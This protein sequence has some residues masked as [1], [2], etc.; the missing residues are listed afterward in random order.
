[1][2][3]N[4]NDNI[5]VS[6]EGKLLD[7][8]WGPFPNTDAAYAAVDPAY[9]Q[10]GMFAIINSPS[11][12]QLWW[13][14]NN[15]DNLVLFSGNSSV[16][17][18][19]VKNQSEPPVPGETFFPP[20]GSVD[21]IY[22]DKSE[23]KSYYWTTA[24]GGKYELTS[25]TSGVEVYPARNGPFPTGFPTEGVE[26]IVYVAADTDYS[27]LWD[28][29]TSTYLQ[30]TNNQGKSAYDIWLEEGNTGTKEDFL[31][32]L[33]GPQGPEGLQGL[34]GPQGE[35]GPAG[36]T[37]P[38][39]PSG[40][41]TING[42]NYVGVWSSL[43]P[44]TFDYGDVVSYNGESYVRVVATSLDN[45]S[46]TPDSNSNWVLLAAQGATG[47]TGPQGPVGDTGPQGPQG[48]GGPQGPQGIDGPQGIAGPQG[49]QG[50]Q[51][52]DGPQGDQGP[53]GD[54]GDMGPA[55]PTGD[56]GPQGVKGDAGPVGPA[57]LTWK[58]A[59]VANTSYSK[60]DAV[61]YAGAS[62]FCLLNHSGISTI[63]SNDP[64]RW[65]LLASQGAVGPQGPT[66]AT[67]ATGPQG[68]VGPQGP[69]GEEGPRGPQGNPGETGAQGPAGVQGPQGPQGLTGPIGLQGPP[70][71]NGQNALWNFTQAYNPGAAYAVGDI[72]TYDGE[73][74]YRLDANG[75]NVGDVPQ[76][77]T[78]WTKLAAKGADGAGNQTLQQV[79]DE[80][81]TATDTNISLVGTSKI[82]FDNLAKLQK[83]TTNAGASGGIALKC[84]VD[85]ELKWEAGR[86]YIMQQ[87]GNT[88]REVRYTLTTPPTANDDTTQG[89]VV[90]S[91]WILDDGTTYVCSDP[92]PGAALWDIEEVSG[93]IDYYVDT[94]TANNYVITTGKSLT[95]NTTGDTYLI[96]FK[97]PNTGNSTLDVDGIGPVNIFNSKTQT[98]LEAGNIPD[99]SVHL[100]VYTG[101][102][103]E[104]VTVGGGT[105]TGD[106]LKSTYDVDN[107]GVVDATE[108]TMFQAKNG[109]AT[110]LTKGTIVYLKTSSSSGDYP[111]VLKANASTETGSSK[112]IGAVY[113]DIA[114]GAVGYIITNGRV[115]NLNTNS[116]NVGDKLW[117]ATTDGEVTTTPPTQPYHTVFIGTVTRKQINN[118]G[119]LYA[120]QNGFEIGEL[121]DVLISFPATGHYIY[122]DATTDP[123][124]PLWK[125]SASWQGNAIAV[126]KGGT[127]FS[128]YTVGDIL[129]ADTTT[130]FAKLQAVASGQVLVSA[131]A[132]TA[133]AWS[134]TPSLSTLT[135]TSTGSLTLGTTGPTG[136]TGQ[137]ILRNST[138]A[139]TLTLQSGA[140]SSSYT[141]TLPPGSPG[142]NQFLQFTSGG[143]AS[144]VSG[145]TTGVSGIGTINSATKSANGAVVSGANLVMQTADASFPGLVSTGE[146]TFAGNKTFSF[147]PTTSAAPL[148][149][150]GNGNT[151]FNVNSQIV[152]TG[153]TMQSIDF[154]GNA[155]T[156][157]GPP[158]WG[159]NRSA[160]TKL[161]LNRSH[162]TISPITD[163]ALGID[164]NT[165]WYSIGG[166]TSAYFHRW[167]GASTQIME[168]N[169]AGQL[170]LTGALVGAAT[171]NVFNTVS[172][173]VSAFGAA[174]TLNICNT[175]TT[176]GRD[177]TLNIFPSTGNNTLTANRTRTLN[178]STGIEYENN[179]SFITTTNI[180][181]GNN[182]AFSGAPTSQTYTNIY[183]SVSLLASAGGAPLGITGAAWTT[184]GLSFSI[185]ARALWD[186][187]SAA[188]TIVATRVAHSIGTPTFRSANAITVTDA[189]NVYIAGNVTAGSGTTITNSW[190]LW[191]EGRVRVANTTAST[192]TTTG[193]LVV[194]GGMGI[195]GAIVAGGAIVSPTHAGSTTTAS[196]LTI[197]ANT[198]DTTTGQ[199]NITTS[200]AS[201]STTT[202]ALTVSGGVGIAG[203]LNVGGAVGI[204]GNV[205]FYGTSPVVKGNT[206]NITGLT[207]GGS[208]GTAVTTGSTFGGYTIA[209]IA[210]AL[211]RLGLIT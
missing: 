123:S 59:W 31:N 162:S 190:G 119:I 118:G 108:R 105:A 36:P 200:T 66:G 176:G 205:G 127:G 187:S 143:V 33:V 163:Y 63:P 27:Y 145:T 93:G 74:W 115:H 173:S 153:T 46:S 117:L 60:D 131:G 177:I 102:N 175:N 64:T 141:L 158:A 126:T 90:G 154:G 160:G 96:K 29:G 130:S 50:V 182:G 14:K 20:T 80:G 134:G 201:T 211:Q 83:G 94:G 12:A 199:V 48:E 1:M 35:T 140:S 25:S 57:G 5:F 54:Q 204:T 169:G 55:G 17:V 136:A 106:M 69:Q 208:G 132:N 77:G 11:G 42:L 147:A 65:A 148:I 6:F 129:Y 89:F 133:P 44:Y 124:N 58:S 37:G 194:S 101:T 170:T 186:T 86:L 7:A 202:G 18:Y 193:S 149:L 178:I 142:T 107:D 138:N 68:P 150:S 76:E 24:E 67:G 165:M 41:V 79:L 207:V 75:G 71:D 120:I 45:G 109:Y 99:E 192:S 164:T 85:Y 146:Q 43:V 111:E 78:I 19:D 151:A 112:T 82:E 114:S 84:S 53:K 15:T 113:E 100:V 122:Y 30:I 49:E 70:G 198:A 195:A 159:S 40:T 172:T 87:D 103:F 156:G 13:Y 166:A 188:S 203:A 110:T 28:K 51:G 161:I 88:I 189:I 56:T 16:Q 91:R 47:P 62:W 104:I 183:G 168:L 185:A 121:H 52:A 206:G 23:S 10:I 155:N 157:S 81:N 180:N 181:I 152:F 197:R 92:N 139:N 21:I 95:V 167:Y 98:T 22:I 32:S 179:G 38:T 135:L 174:S 4:F 73:T 26:G 8:K 209:Q 128:S 39:G 171:Q 3:I 61:G 196:N 116:Y 191:S 2:A 144:W 210:A 125:N 9:R 184:T 34:T 97:N 137:I 72:V